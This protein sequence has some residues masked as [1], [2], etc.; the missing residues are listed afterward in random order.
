M[1][2]GGST[3]W[4]GTA[5]A[6]CDNSRIILRHSEFTREGGYVI[7]KI[8]GNSGNITGQAVSVVNDTYVSHLTITA[9]Q[10]VNGSIIECVGGST[11]GT[12]FIS[13]NSSKE[14]GIVH[15]SCLYLA[16]IVL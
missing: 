7:R 13:L 9:S 14:R 15:L 11:N 8:C 4:K 12:K 6:N 10:E 16:I 2:G 5:L 1:S 3:T